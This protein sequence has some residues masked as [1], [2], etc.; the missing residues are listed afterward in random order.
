VV[1]LR[2]LDLL[3]HQRLAGIYLKL[4]QSDKAIEHL[5]S[6]QKLELSDDRYAK[7]I[8]K[9]Y[10]RDKR[11]DE[12]TR[13]ALQAIYVDPY[14]LSAHELLQEIYQGSGNAEGLAREERVIPLLTQWIED[15]RKAN[16]LHPSRPE[17]NGE[18]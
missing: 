11:W 9:I 14:D 13:F 18:Q 6:L 8:A 4:N 17:S 15:Q 2:P 7:A 16:D 12:A 3:P 1:V 10:K 5:E